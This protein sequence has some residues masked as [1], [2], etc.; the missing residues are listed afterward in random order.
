M[1]PPDDRPF[2]H[3]PLRA[4]PRSTSRRR[5]RRSLTYALLFLWSLVVLVPLYWVFITSFKGA[6]EVDNGPF[7]I[8]F[9]DFRPNLERLALHAPREQHPRPL[10]ELG[11]GGARQHDPRRA[12]RLARRLRA[13][14]HPLPGE[15]RG[16]RGLPPAPAVAVIIAVVTFGVPWQLALASRGRALPPRARHAGAPHARRASAT[17]TS[18]SGSSPTASCR[19]SS[20]CCRS[21]SC[22]SSSGSSTPRPR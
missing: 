18:S 10:P 6:G 12:H 21:T 8:P 13:G 16:G 2:A 15:A 14:A 22:S 1:S 9:V 5:R 7:Y 4:R 17:T 11:G 3:A 20:R 19:P